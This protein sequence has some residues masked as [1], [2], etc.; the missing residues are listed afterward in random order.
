MQTAIF[1]G[2]LFAPE[3][4]FEKQPE[5]SRLAGRAEPLHTSSRAPIYAPRAERRKP[6]VEQVRDHPRH[7]PPVPPPAEPAIHGRVI[8]Q[9]RGLVRLVAAEVLATGIADMSIELHRARR[10]PR[11]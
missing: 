6:A 11:P 8:G 2:T 1:S 5:C 4:P 9:R 10:P 3:L 7:F